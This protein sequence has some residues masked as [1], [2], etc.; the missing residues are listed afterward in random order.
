MP[1]KKHTNRLARESSPYLLQHAHNPVDW[2]PWGEEAL[3]RAKGEGR[4]ILLSIGYSACHWCHVMEHESFENEAIAEMMNRHFVNIKVDREERPDLDQIYQ[5]AVQLFG[6]SGG[7]PLT[8]FL[9]PDQEP[10][11]G[12]TYFPPDSRYGRPGFPSVLLSVARFY[13]TEKQKV[14]EGVAQVR[15]ALAQMNQASAD[16]EEELTAGLLGEAGEHLAR[17]FDTVHGGFGAQ[18][19]FPN[20]PCLSLLLRLGR[21]PDAARY[22]EMACLALR[23]MS[24]GGIFDQLGG[25]YHR[26]S[27][28][29]QWLVPH[30]EKMLYDNALI[31]RVNLEAFQCTGEALFESAA[32]STLDFVLREM[33][34]EEGGFYSTLD[35]DSEGEEG[36]FYVWTPEQIVEVLGPRDGKLLCGYY[37]VTG[38]G[39]LEGTAASVLSVCGSAE[40]PGF[41]LGIP[42]ESIPALLEE[43]R[44]RLL[45]AREK[46]V[47]PFRDEKILTAW[48]GLMISAFAE[49]ARV[50]EEP[51]FAAA[52]RRSADFGLRHLLSGSTLLHGFKDG[53]GRIPGYLDDYAYFVAALLDVSELTHEGGYQEQALA[54]T[55]ATLHQFWD[56]QHGGF[57]FTPREHERLIHRPKTATDHAMPSATSACALNLL[58][59]FSLTE[60]VEFRER[61]A[62]VLRLHAREMKENPFGF[63]GLLSVL[64]AYLEGL[65]EIVVVGDPDEAGTREI[66]RLIHRR[67]QPNKVMILVRPGD[68]LPEGAPDI[69]KGKKQRDGRTTVYV[70][71]HFTC[72]APA[73]TWEEIEPLLASSATLG[74]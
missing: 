51:R 21:R 60:R 7:W 9:T 67:Y 1:L 52:A 6:Q 19:K 13:R 16:G 65:R 39:N 29:A 66:F 73:T 59:L 4:P 35:A 22:R 58:R 30:F 20:V 74:G 31:A 37:G 55:H 38:A 42:V 71:R 49:A 34:D 18:P 61:A 41:D 12:G 57:F 14:A 43:G 72:S 11:Y 63:A 25:G 47:R 46:R 56:E 3:A 36:K 5:A 68:K 64:D 54:L 24:E 23:K 33:T 62:D 44:R 8:V 17:Y 70:C 2:Y 50:L 10:F 28:D 26:Y 15:E 53:E 48:N 27:V 45:E 40:H 69:L 32:R